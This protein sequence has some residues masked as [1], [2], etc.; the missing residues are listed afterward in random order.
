MQTVLPNFRL[1]VS[2]A[3]ISL[4]LVILDSVG[5]LNGPKFLLQYITV[6]VQYGLHQMGQNMDKQVQAFLLVRQSALE[7]RALKVQM[8]ELLTENAQLRS[9]LAE[10]ESLVDQYNKLSPQTYDLLPARVISSGRYLNIDKG[11]ADGVKVGQTVV[12]KDNYIGQVK[13]VSPKSSRVMMEADPDSKIA[14]FAQD[15]AGRAKGILSGQFG[16]ELLMDKILHQET[17]AKDDLVY[18]DGT[19]D[20]LPRGLIMGK[21]SRVFQRQNELFQQA[22]ITPLVNIDDLDIVYII[23]S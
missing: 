12:Y 22:N 10:T 23:R 16:A 21:V 13:E 20:Q 15:A 9:Q 14:V 4:L 5:F 7:N 18:S 8:G 11:S 6:P 17:I 3:F 2:L 1:F 19:E